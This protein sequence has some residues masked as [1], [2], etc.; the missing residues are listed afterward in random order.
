MILQLGKRQHLVGQRQQMLSFLFHN[1]KITFL[2]FRL[3]VQTSA[4]QNLRSHQDGTQW[5]LHIVNH[6]I[7]KV[8]PHLGYLILPDNDTNLIHNTDND[9]YHNQH[10]GNQQ[11]SHTLENHPVRIQN[12]P[13]QIASICLINRHQPCSQVFLSFQFC[14]WRR[15]PQYIT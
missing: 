12:H 9:Q 14:L 1:T 4:F 2:L 3:S 10:R 8:L 6:G 7:R 5:S 15:C 11:Q 13:L